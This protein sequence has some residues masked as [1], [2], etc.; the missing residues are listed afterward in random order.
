M[1]TEGRLRERGIAAES[2]QYIYLHSRRLVSTNQPTGQPPSNQ[3]VSTQKPAARPN[4]SHRPDPFF[5]IKLSG[6]VGFARSVG[7][8]TFSCIHV[9]IL[10]RLSPDRVDHPRG[11]P[12]VQMHGP[13]RFSG[14]PKAGLLWGSLLAGL[15]CAG[16]SRPFFVR[17]L[18]SHF[19]LARLRLAR[20]G[21]AVRP[22]FYEVS[23]MPTVCS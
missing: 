16:A 2:Q 8:V 15:R 19:G 20:R 5:W 7:D 3:G 1:R 9:P 10:S 11:A 6:R 14:H 18:R 23:D 13:A 22:A 17:S 21:P 4:H 12:I